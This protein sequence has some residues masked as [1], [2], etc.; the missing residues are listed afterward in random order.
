[1]GTGGE[2]R[3]SPVRRTLDAAPG[4]PCQ[5][6]EKGTRPRRGRQITGSP[7][8]HQQPFIQHAGSGSAFREWSEPR[9]T[10]REQQTRRIWTAAQA[11]YVSWFLL[12]GQPSRKE[13]VLESPMNGLVLLFAAQ[14]L[15]FLE[16]PQ[17]LAHRA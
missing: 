11:G 8:A 15:P 12:S 3:A 5:G 13:R 10:V 1:M 7:E 16:E 6:G 9:L 4:H 14:D 2:K 17:C